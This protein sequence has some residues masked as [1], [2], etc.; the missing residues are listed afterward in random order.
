VIEKVSFFN[1]HWNEIETGGASARIKLAGKTRILVRAYDRM[2]GNADRRRLGVYSVG[3]AVYGADGNV[4]SDH[5]SAITFK[6]LPDDRAVRFTYGPGS[7]SGAT[8]ETIFNYIASNEVDAD[9]FKEDF[10][11]VSGY[12]PGQYLIRVYVADY[13]GN[14]TTKDLNFE[15]I[16]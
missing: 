10:L 8:G 3:Y 15:V 16:K 6:R 5:Q 7:K 11:D 14:T 4:I 12:V 1:E 2:D 9:S 13:F